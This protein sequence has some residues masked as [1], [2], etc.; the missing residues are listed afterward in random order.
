MPFPGGAQVPLTFVAELVAGPRDAVTGV[1][2]AFAE[3]TN[4]LVGDLSNDIGKIGNTWLGGNYLNTNSDTEKKASLVGEEGSYIIK[5]GDVNYL[6]GL[7]HFAAQF[8]QTGLAEAALAAGAQIAATT[9]IV[10]KEVNGNGYNE[11]QPLHMAALYGQTK[12]I[13]LLVAKGANVDA[14]CTYKGVRLGLHRPLHASKRPPKPVPLLKLT[15]VPPTG[16]IGARWCGWQS[17][18]ILAR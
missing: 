11:L 6:N 4:H 2:R 9:S 3:A 15:D 16:G 18:R 17:F 1:E 13:P 5:Y 10:V 12:M 7:L 14:T 8:G